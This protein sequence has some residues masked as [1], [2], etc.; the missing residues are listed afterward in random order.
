MG[1]SALTLKDKFEQLLEATTAFFTDQQGNIAKDREAVAQMRHMALAL[2]AEVE[3]PRTFERFLAYLL[4]T[5]TIEA[6]YPLHAI[7]LMC[8]VVN[9]LR[10]NDVTITQ[11]DEI[12]TAAFFADFGCRGAWLSYQNAHAGAAIFHLR[13]LA[14]QW[15]T[16][17]V[18]RMIL[19]HHDP[20]MDPSPKHIFSVAA[21]FL[22]LTRGTGIDVAGQDLYSPQQAIE[23]IIENNALDAEGRKLFLNAFSVYPLGSWVRLNTGEIGLV[24]ANHNA[25]NPLRPIVGIYH[26]GQSYGMRRSEPSCREVDLK[27]HVTTFIAGDIQPTAEQKNLFLAPH[28]WIHNWNRFSVEDEPAVEELPEAPVPDKA[29]IPRSEPQYPIPLQVKGITFEVP[30]PEAAS[31]LPKEPAGIANFVTTLPPAPLQ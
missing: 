1:T 18:E 10:Q 7:Q 26:E 15:W 29:E 11:R 9:T 23:K 6:L 27:K 2:A 21:Q 25:G 28:L 14:A 30:G 3:K 22:A 5:H 13:D 31:P 16:P 4:G 8:L 20:Q 24:I 19:F 17:W 12:A